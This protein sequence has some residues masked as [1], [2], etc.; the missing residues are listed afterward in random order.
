MAT[1]TLQTRLLDV[2]G[3]DIVDPAVT[4]RLQS[5]TAPTTRNTTVEAR[6]MPLVVPVE[7]PGGSGLTIR[8]SPSRY[9]DAGVV[10]SPTAGRL[11]LH[12]V[13]LARRPREW[14]PAFDAWSA[15]PAEFAG[16]KT[17]LE[18]SKRFQVGRVS[19]PGQFVGAR[20][21]AVDGSDE[22]SALAKMCL[23]NLC[24]RLRTEAIPGGSGVWQGGITELLQAQQDRIFGL[25]RA[26]FFD[27]VARLARKG[28]GGYS[29]SNAEN[30]RHRVEALVGVEQVGDMA[31][32]KS[33][34]SKANIQ[35]TV[36]KVTYR[37]AAAFVVDADIDEDGTLLGH[38][39]EFIRNFL[40]KHETHPI[41]IHESLRQRFADAVLG[42][43]LDPRQPV[44][45]VTARIIAAAAVA[46]PT[47][48]PTAPAAIAPAGARGPARIAVVGDSV[49]WGQ[50][51]LRAQKMHELVANAYATVGPRPA[52]TLV[53][54]S[55][56]VIGVGTS[57]TA[58]VCDGEVP[59]GRPTI[60]QQVA[61]F[62]AAEARAT[63]L[64]IVNGGINDV[65]IRVI[66]NPLTSTTT[67][68]DK[69]ARACGDDLLVLLMAALTRFPAARLAVLAYYPI[70]SPLSRFGEGP[71]FVA[72]LGAPMALPFA[73]GG[74]AAT[75]SVW[76]K[77][78]DNC[79]VFHQ[80]SAQ[81]I[82]RAVQAANGGAAGRCVLVDPGFTDEQAALAPDARLFGINVDL[83][84][85][86]PVARQRRLACDR[87]EKDLLRREVCHR[88]SAGHPNPRGAEDYAAAIIAALS[89]SDAV[90]VKR[91]TRQP[92]R[93]RAR[94]RRS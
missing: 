72:A 10:G 3:F 51:L 48:H 12:P 17:L 37:G 67:L 43:G 55:G 64:V 89:R 25:V 32:I 53:A 75:F 5:T 62:D 54:H 45:V 85:Q 11:S 34:D 77:I 94:G 93:A 56:A 13:V 16:L 41:D 52:T 74:A 15:L 2:D 73:T 87:C 70:L 14:Q 78:V 35:L 79:R 57:S 90:P 92:A 22:S 65:D 38:T 7:A 26:S 28:A 60:L 20:Y 44:G 19:E 46:A 4:F 80:A 82:R 63:D 86:D 61:A 18:D 50:G 29:R 66:L 39:F 59:K 68:A 36:A 84:P 58:S 81:A 6:G 24:S 40:T 27:H 30:H 76:D 23:L 49:P 47:A 21:D 83:S 69:T 31:S 9:R 91:R 1:V 71:Q 8:I 42:Y 33:G 88:A